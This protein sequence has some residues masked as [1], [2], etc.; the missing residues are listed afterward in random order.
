MEERHIRL[1]IEFRLWHAYV[2]LV[3]VLAASVLFT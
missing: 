1:H 3:A 2:V